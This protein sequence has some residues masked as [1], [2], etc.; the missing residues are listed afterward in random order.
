MSDARF[1]NSSFVTWTVGN[2]KKSFSQ[3]PA[4]KRGQV[5]AI[6]AGKLKKNRPPCL[7]RTVIRWLPDKGA[8]C[9]V[10]L[11]GARFLTNA[12]RQPKLNLVSLREEKRPQKE[13]HN[14]I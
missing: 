12:G 8:V 2:E 13:H 14:L 10:R 11:N 1:Q 9:A 5:R 4:K 6:I 7:S 3:K